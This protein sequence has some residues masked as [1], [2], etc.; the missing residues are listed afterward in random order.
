L[1]ASPSVPSAIGV[2]WLGPST[3]QLPNGKD[4][5]E[6]SRSGRNT[7][8]HVCALRSYCF[9]GASARDDR[10][11]GPGP[12]LRSADGCLFRARRDLRSPLCTRL[13]SAG[14]AWRGRELCAGL[15]WGAL[16]DVLPQGC[17]QTTLTTFVL[18]FSGGSIT[19]P[20]ILD[21]TFVGGGVLVQHGSGQIASGT[22]SY[23]GATG[24][25]QTNGNAML[26]D[27]IHLTLVIRLN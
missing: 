5:H 18:T 13:A 11:Q 14:S 27:G 17:N 22:G 9:C 8:L 10:R 1:V 25:L 4:W 23:A 2:A 19:A 7:R 21:E 12:H 24:T 26:P 3:N 20:M 15:G 6:A 16:P